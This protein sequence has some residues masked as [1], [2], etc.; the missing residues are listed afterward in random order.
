MGQPKPGVIMEMAI[1]LF[2]SC[3]YPPSTAGG[4]QG[5][6]SAQYNPDGQRRETPR[7]ERVKESLGG[8]CEGLQ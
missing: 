6:C 8:E 2:P 5:S 4:T 7:E 3:L 1:N